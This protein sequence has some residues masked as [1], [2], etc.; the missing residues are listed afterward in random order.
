[1]KYFGYGQIVWAFFPHVIFIGFEIPS[2]AQNRKINRNDETKFSTWMRKLINVSFIGFTWNKCHPSNITTSYSVKLPIF[3]DNWNCLNWICENRSIKRR[4]VLKHKWFI[5][6]MQINLVQS[7]MLLQMK[8]GKWQVT[9]I[10]YVA[11]VGQSAFFIKLNSFS[12]C[13]CLCYRCGESSRAER[14]M[15]IERNDDKRSVTKRANK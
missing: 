8:T 4:K 9:S 3:W 2:I 12:I 14:M 1:M 6:T 5:T 11:V 15:S 13:S 10:I 7:K